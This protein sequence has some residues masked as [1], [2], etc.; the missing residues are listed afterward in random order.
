MC[1]ILCASGPS[2]VGIMDARAA[3]GGGGGDQINA[4]ACIETMQKDNRS[5]DFQVGRH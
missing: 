5:T 2:K 3:D 1:G 4:E